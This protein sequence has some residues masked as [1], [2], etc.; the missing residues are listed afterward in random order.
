MPVFIK[1][2]SLLRGP[3]LVFVEKGVIQISNNGI[4]TKVG[5]GEELSPMDRGS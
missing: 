3:D 1:N 2:A 4:I 5:I